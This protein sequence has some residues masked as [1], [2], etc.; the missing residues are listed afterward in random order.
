MRED[1]PM[2]Y[3]AFIAVLSGA[4]GVVGGIERGST[5][6]SIAAA[7][8]HIGGIIGMAVSVRREEQDCG[9]DKPAGEEDDTC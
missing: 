6:G 5:A 2:A 9:A 8:I 7:V 3:I 1:K 4:A